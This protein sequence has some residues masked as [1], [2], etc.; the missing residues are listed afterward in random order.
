MV[1][2]V[3]GVMMESTRINIAS[4][5]SPVPAGRYE[6]D[7]PHSGELFRERI[8]RSALQKGAKVSVE[9]DGAEGFGSSFLEEAFGG[10]VR[11]GYFTKEE[12]HSRLEIL[13]KDEALVEE[14]WEYIEH[15][16]L[17]NAH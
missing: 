2:D 16:T 5:F 15:A 6:T 10:L 1:C 7:G 8:L 14:I 9:M 3:S 13:S 12:L 4:D 17:E 11:L